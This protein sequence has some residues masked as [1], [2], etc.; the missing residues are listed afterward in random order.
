MI[1]STKFKLYTP[2]SNGYQK[3]TEMCLAIQ[4]PLPMEGSW[5]PRWGWGW[6]CPHP[7]L[8]PTP[9]RSQ[10]AIPIYTLSPAISPCVGLNYVGNVIVRFNTT[11]RDDIN[12]H[13]HVVPGL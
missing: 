4:H 5:C 10:S 1:G 9:L 13:Q 11:T 2:I 7:D 6:G 3:S 12:F 8:C